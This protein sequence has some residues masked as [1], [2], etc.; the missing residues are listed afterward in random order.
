VV[1]LGVKMRPLSPPA[2]EPVAFLNEMYHEYLS[3]GSRLVKTTVPFTSV[4]LLRE[5]ASFPDTADTFG[6]ADEAKERS[7]ITARKVVVPRRDFIFNPRAGC[8]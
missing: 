7:K 4:I 8:Y 6:S 1:V 5:T 3:V 2:Y